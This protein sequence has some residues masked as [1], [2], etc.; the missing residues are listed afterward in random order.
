MSDELFQQIKEI[1]NNCQ[2]LF[3]K[4][5]SVGQEYEMID[6]DESG[7]Y[8]EDEERVCRHWDKLTTKLSEALREGLEGT[9][10]SVRKNPDPGSYMVIFD[11]TKGETETC[12]LDVDYS[13]IGQIAIECHD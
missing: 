8:E 5:H 13:R 2:H 3:A 12:R 1:F 7:L 9:V 10:V 11:I 4:L 6:F